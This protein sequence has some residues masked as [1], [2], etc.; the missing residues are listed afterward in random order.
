MG[1]LD[2]L[3]RLIAGV[4][5][6]WSAR[7]AGPHGT[8]LIEIRR[9]VLEEVKS[10]IES[11]GRGEYMFRYHTVAVR[12]AAADAAG[13]ESCEAAFV[14][15]DSLAK[16]IRQ[17]LAEA[18][19]APRDF[20]VTITVEED[21][22]AASKPFEIRFERKAQPA[23]APEPV[24][25]RAAKLTVLRGK[26]NTAEGVF[27]AS[28]INIGRLEEVVS[29]SGGLIRRNALAFDES[30]ATVAREHAYIQR[31][32]KTGDFRLCDYLSGQRGTRV[33]REGRSIPVPRASGRGV[34]LHSGDEIHLGEARLRFEI[35]EK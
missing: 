8:S 34:Q 26:A 2:R 15:E 19:C 3:E 28:R 18:R 6:N 7:F 27:D 14:E 4:V 20:S 32:P 5:E 24:K 35:V 16:E 33:F 29:E 31:D 22:A 21:P 13:R 11:K 9:G 30:E 10:R 23:A 25:A 12:I 17:L 1:P